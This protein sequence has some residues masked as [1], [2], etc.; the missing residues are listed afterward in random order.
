M[1]SLKSVSI[2][3]EASLFGRGDLDLE[4]VFQCLLVLNNL[5]SDDFR[6]IILLI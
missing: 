4:N 3:S 5:P 6:E 2:D 1:L